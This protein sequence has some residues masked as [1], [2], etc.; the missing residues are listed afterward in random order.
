MRF[1]F[2][3]LISWGIEEAF[4]RG[5]SSAERLNAYQKG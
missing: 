5:S 2:G 1:L 4:R 3:Q